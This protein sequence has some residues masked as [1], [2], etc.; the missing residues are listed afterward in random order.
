MHLRSAVLSAACMA[1]AALGTVPAPAD[2]LCEFQKV[3]PPDAQVDQDF[4]WDIA[5]SGD[6]VVIGADEDDQNGNRSG[7]VYLYRRIA[8]AWSLET[9]LLASDGQ[10]GDYLGT[11]VAIQNEII[12]AGARL[13]DG[14][15]IESGAVYLFSFDPEYSA[16]IEN[17]KLVAS[18][19][20][21]TDFFGSAVALH[22]DVLVVGAKLDDDAGQ[23]SGAA[24]VYRFD[25]GA[26]VWTQE[27][28]L[29]ASDGATADFFGSAVAITGSAVLVGAPGDEGG[30]VYVF[31]DD[32]DGPAWLEEARL[33]ISNSG[34]LDRF[35]ISIAVDGNLAVIGAPNL[36]SSSPGKAYTF[37]F[38]GAAWSET[39]LLVSSGSE[40]DDRFGGA[41][42]VAGGRA[43]V[44]SYYEDNANG[45]HAG[46][47]YVFE[48]DPEAS[49]WQ[50]VARL[51]PPH[52]DPND[53]FGAATATDGMRAVIGAA[54]DEGADGPPSSGA[55]YFYGSFSLT[56]D[57]NQNLID[58]SCELLLGLD[59]DCNENMV[60]DSCDI[61]DGTS[62][63]CNCNDVPDECDIADGTSHDTNG[64]GVPDECP[65]SEFADINDDGSVNV[66][67]FLLL[68]QA[69]GLC[70]DPPQECPEDVDGD[71]AVG[72]VDVLILLAN[73][74]GCP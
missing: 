74:T 56:E 7:A 34:N 39:Q 37:E 16:W 72:M 21:Q 44:G 20:A 51:L 66:L 52:G 53:L 42:A 19:G 38:D 64:D 2:D 27:F 14:S 8:G 67:D 60:L 35:G 13:A 3:V 45:Y 70:P 11:S 25:P 6:L 68:I 48:Y 58:D 24:Y 50:E 41:V 22:G 15:A 28:K 23:S 57:C 17:A 69:W 40:T 18:D 33:F 36:S 59:F 46:A 31:R 26:S 55:A 5:L 43:V 30:S 71:G 9:K 54:H 61:A 12:V 32:P 65:N 73:W 10:A 63:D 29:T 1:A 4:G 47:A 62:G 49:S